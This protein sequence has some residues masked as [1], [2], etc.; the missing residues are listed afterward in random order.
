MDFT[1]EQIDA[2]WNNAYAPPEGYDKNLYRLDS[3]GALIYYPKRGEQTNMGWEIDHIYPREK[4]GDASIIN[5][6][7]MQ[8]QNNSRKSDAYPTFQCAV[9]YSELSQKNIDCG[10]WIIVNDSRR[11]SLSLVYGGAR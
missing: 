3:C 7:A 6:Q 5:L 4:G 9:R 10:D 8:H 2:A 1:Q 11:K